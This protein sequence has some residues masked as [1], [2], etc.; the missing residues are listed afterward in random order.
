MT[1]ASDQ[2]QG[3]LIVRLGD[4]AS[5]GAVTRITLGML[6]LCHRG[7]HGT[8]RPLTPGA[9]V[10]VAVRLDQ[11]AYRLAAGHRLRL[12]LSTQYWPFIWPSPAAPTLTVEVAGAVLD[13]PVRDPGAAKPAD[14]VSTGGNRAA[15]TRRQVCI[16]QVSGVTTLEVADDSGLATGAAVRE[17]YTIHPD[18]PLWARVKI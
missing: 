17:V 14:N 15:S 10:T 8:P 4:V 11:M 16:D 18:D 13:L 6:N 9:A 1:L 2:P 5:D 3:N 7:D 12:S